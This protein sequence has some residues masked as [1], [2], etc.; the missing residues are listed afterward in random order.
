[1]VNM[2]VTNNSDSIGGLHGRSEFIPG[3]E[4]LVKACD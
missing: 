3:T 4:N 1:M 2:G